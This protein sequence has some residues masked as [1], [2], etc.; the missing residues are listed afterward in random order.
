MSMPDPVIPPTWIGHRIG[1]DAPRSRSLGDA[2]IIHES[3]D[4]DAGFAL[5]DGPEPHVRQRPLEF[6]FRGGYKNLRVVDFATE[7]QYRL[8]VE[9]EPMLRL[10]DSLPAADGVAEPRATPDLQ[11]LFQ[12]SGP[13]TLPV[14]TGDEDS[15]VRIQ[16]TTVFPYSAVVHLSVSVASGALIGDNVVLT[17]AHC[18]VNG[19]IGKDEGYQVS[20]YGNT[21]MPGM[22]RSPDCA[23]SSS[24]DICKLAPFGTLDVKYA[25]VPEGWLTPKGAVPLGDLVAYDPMDWVDDIAVLI[26]QE[27]VD[28]QTGFFDCRQLSQEQLRSAA[29]LNRGY[30]GPG[31]GA[32]PP[33]YQ[34]WQLW[35]DSRYASVDGFLA[36]VDGVHRLFTHSADTS[37]GHS[38]SPLFQWHVSVDQGWRPEVVGIVSHH[39]RTRNYA[40]RIMAD[41]ILPD[42]GR[43]VGRGLIDAG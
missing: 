2:H 17:A 36:E 16:P 40:R 37:A 31:S 4:H 24:A 35:G 29:L 27:P 32:L 18:V 10:R 12:V 21:V 26:L 28:R 33:G 15:R 20:W 13:R 7:R 1:L 41:E 34:P 42:F 5:P 39:Q 6:P 11:E 14:V 22:D 3:L 23:D 19:G 8:S 30:P 38:G 9:T 43:S 25:I